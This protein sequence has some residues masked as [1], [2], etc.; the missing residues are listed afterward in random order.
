[1][2]SLFELLVAVTGL[3]FLIVAHDLFQRRKFNFLHFLVFFGGSGMIV[4]FVIEPTL[5]ERFGQFFGI[6]RGADLLVY[7]SIIFLV[8]LYFESL[9]QLT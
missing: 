5:L 9:I 1:M 8:Y 6:A 4:L 2:M 7:M 3:I